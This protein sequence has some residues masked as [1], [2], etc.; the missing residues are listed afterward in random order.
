MLIRSE[1]WEIL[2]RVRIIKLLEYPDNL[3]FISSE[4][5]NKRVVARYEYH[6]TQYLRDGDTRCSPHT[7]T[8]AVLKRKKSQEYQYFYCIFLFTLA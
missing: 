2:E 7:I 6:K 1:E 8:A 3:K 4:P 5:R